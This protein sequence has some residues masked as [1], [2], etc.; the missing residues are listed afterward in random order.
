MAE[1]TPT[2]VSP[3]YLRN[4]TQALEL[5][6]ATGQVFVRTNAEI[7]GNVSVGNV[8]IGALGNVDISGNELPVTIESGNVT[9]FQG[10][11]PWTVSGNVNVDTITG[12][13]AGITANVTVVDGGGSLTVDG[14]VGIVGNV[15][16]TQGTSP[17][18]V[19]GNVTSYPASGATNYFGTPLVTTLVPAIQINSYEGIKERE[20]Q[21]YTGGGGTVAENDTDIDVSSTSTVGSYAVYRSERFIPYRSGQS[22]VS[23]SLSKFSTP[24]LLTQQRVGVA[25]QEAGY[26]VGYNG[27]NDAAGNY[28]DIKFLHTFGGRAEVWSLTVTGTASANQTITLTLNSTVYNI[29]VLSGDTA[30]TIA[31]KIAQTVNDS[32]WLANAADN[33]VKLLSGSLG[34]LTGTFSVTSTGN[35]TFSLVQAINGV[36]GTDEWHGITLP[37]GYDPTSYNTWQFRYAWSGVEL[38][39]LDPLTNQMILI[40]HHGLADDG[41]LPVRKPSF[42]TTAVAYNTGG[43]TPV[44]VSVAYMFGAVEGEEYITKYTNGGGVTKASLASGT[45]HHILSIQ[46]PFV[47][48]NNL[49]NFRSITFLDLTAAVQANDPVELYIVFNPALVGGTFNWTQVPNRL[50]QQSTAT[51]TIDIVNNTPL[52]A[53]VAG[54]SGSGTQFDLTDYRV[55]LPP[56]YHM[57]L[58][59]Y[60]QASIQKLTAG[61][62]WITAS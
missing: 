12:N 2:E 47:A 49:L 23:R 40:L 22:C 62:T 18:V 6:E 19:S 28:D 8:A 4:I 30:I 14:N 1:P 29:A 11:D 55:V 32:A 34:D 42:K 31:T 38:Y 16:V 37:A 45:Y 20:T 7:I 25:N 60:S 5:N 36:A 48:D 27:A 24:A 15:N 59:A 3:W 56:G 44:T 17:W 57:S 52:A 35:V 26:Y 41:M 61:G 51:G 13:I 53:L 39:L 33:V 50:Y 10:T 46:N 43:S 58:V 9:V 21:V 54:I